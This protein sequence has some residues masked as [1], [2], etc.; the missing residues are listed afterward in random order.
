MKSAIYLTALCLFFG[1]SQSEQNGFTKLHSDD[2]GIAFNNVNVENEQINIFTYEYLYNGGGV[3]VGDINND[4][5]TDVYFSSNNLENKLYLNKG[6]F[7]FEDITS[8]SGTGCQQGWKTGVS[9][10]D[11]NADGWLDIYVCRS[12]DGNPTRR[13]NSL[14]INNGDLTFTD[15]ASEYGLADESYTTQAAFFDYDRDGDLDVFLLNHSLLQISNSFNISQINRIARYPHVGNRFLRNDDGQFVDISEDAGIYGP[16]SN[17]GLGVGVSDFNND[18]WPD[19]YVSNDYVDSDKLFLNDQNGRFINATDSLLS[20]MS[21][22]SMGLDIADIN[23]DGNMDI[24]TLDMLPEDNKRQKLLFGPE[25]YFVHASMK[26][27]GYSSQCMRNMLHLNNGNGSFSEVGQIAGISNT[28]WSWAALFADFDNDGF[29]DLFVSNGYK[30]D[31]TNNDFL[32]FKADQEIKKSK[33]NGV[34]NTEMIKKMPSSKQSNYMFKNSGKLVFNNVSDDWGFDEPI[35]TNGAA[36]ADL[37]ND[38]D[39]DMILNN[40]DATAGIYRNDVGNNLANNF[41]KIQLVGADQNRLAVGAKVTV[42]AK[43]AMIIR[44]QYPVRGFQSSIDPILHFGLDSISSVD[45]IHV[46]WPQGGI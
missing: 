45:S 13:K 44:E 23:R 18:G 36:Y 41:I 27:N 7:K 35:L 16:S 17:Y 10:V 30:R 4:G 42:F 46:S 33:T 28:D 14:L 1:C 43:G 19:L 12:A 5:L 39:L 38:G 22:F 24:M 15:L 32:K 37:D 25:N 31:F 9:M 21:Q 8:S 34:N 11:I 3:A 29:Q 2:T 6:D 40:M 26:K 20:Q